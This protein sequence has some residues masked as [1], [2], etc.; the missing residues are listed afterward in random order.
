MS[1]LILEFCDFWE[2]LHGPDAEN[3]RPE[4]ELGRV[5]HFFFSPLPCADL[6]ELDAY[7]EILRRLSNLRRSYEI[8]QHDARQRLRK[9]YAFTAVSLIPDRSPFDPKT[10]SLLP[11]FSPIPTNNPACDG[12]IHRIFQHGFQMNGEILR[13]AVVQ[14]YHAID[15]R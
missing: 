13:K 15:N 5:E 6:L 2:T 9:R 8:A 1:G 7:P 14:C 11:G 10:C 3:F 4:T 12:I